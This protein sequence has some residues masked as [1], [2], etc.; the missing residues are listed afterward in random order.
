MTRLDT[1]FNVPSLGLERQPIAI[2]RKGTEQLG[3]AVDAFRTTQE[4]VIKP[5]NKLVRKNKN[6]SGSTIISS[7]EVVLML[8]VSNL[9]LTK[10]K[11]L[12]S[13]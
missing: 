12:K 10:R 5:L 7:G 9:M 8:D 2:V 11:V 1:L 6:F 3:L 4:V 13:E